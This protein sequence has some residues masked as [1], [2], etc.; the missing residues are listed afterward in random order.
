MHTHKL[1]VLWPRARRA[2]EEAFPNDPTDLDTV[3]AIVEELVEV[4]PA[5]MSFATP[6]AARAR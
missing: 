4:D 1:E 3:E 6:E 2:I 5:S